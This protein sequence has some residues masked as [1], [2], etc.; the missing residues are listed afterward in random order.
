MRPCVRLRQQL[1]HRAKTF[2]IAGVRHRHPRTM[3]LDGA[4]DVFTSAFRNPFSPLPGTLV[5]ESD[6]TTAG[7]D[8]TF[9]LREDEVEEQEH[10][11]ENKVG[12]DPAGDRAVCAIRLTLE[13]HNGL[14]DGA[15]VY[16]R[17]D[18]APL[19]STATRCN[20]GLS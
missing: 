14:T 15:W 10:G 16:R 17:W 12:H 9:N 1:A 11:E 5:L 8:D 18:V 2:Y 4:S 7:T 19:C 3:I 6:P 13:G 20:S